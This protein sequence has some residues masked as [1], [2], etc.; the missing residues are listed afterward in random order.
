[1]GI[2]IRPGLQAFLRQVSRQYELVIFTA[3]QSFYANEVL[4][5]IDPS[6]E[7]ISYRLFHEHCFRSA[8][9][10]LIKDLRILKNRAPGA[11]VLVDNAA[12]SYALQP[13]NGVPVLPFF[14]DKKDAELPDLA[15]YLAELAKA[16]DVREQIARDFHVDLFAAHCHDP[17]A[18]KDLIAA[19]RKR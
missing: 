16:P 1:M 14:A 13:A 5:I 15:A 19:R 12:Y 7:L 11:T 17:P 8:G 10:H 18:L 9:G 3:S 6:N 2:N 4:N